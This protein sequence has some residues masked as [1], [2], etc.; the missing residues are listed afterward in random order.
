MG[1]FRGLRDLTVPTLLSLLLLAGCSRPAGIA[2]DDATTSTDQ[3]VPFH[4]DG[5]TTASSANVTPI[6]KK[7]EV[8]KP[9]TE[10][11]FRDAESL[12][13]GTLLTVRLK[14]PISAENPVAKGTF[15]AVLDEPV[16][17]EGNTLVPRGIPV[18]GRVESAHA[19]KVKRNRGYLRL[20][21]DFIGLAGKDVPI[22]TS[23][24]FA[25]GIAPDSDPSAVTLEK[26]RRLTF[27][28]AEPVL[29]APQQ[30]ISGR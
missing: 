16:V 8:Q 19:S 17:S 12:P 20:T 28:L 13:A 27:R 15:E 5:S 9:E 3:Q 6:S 26:G 11:P 22:Q 23:S 21:L 30:V 4:E 1:R 2:A 25:R 29:I 18:A 14:N 7:D 24:L 10:L